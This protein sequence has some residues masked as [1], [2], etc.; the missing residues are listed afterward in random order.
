MFF[1]TFITDVLKP[2]LLKFNHSKTRLF[3]LEFTPELLGTYAAED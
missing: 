2:I 3:I 1:F